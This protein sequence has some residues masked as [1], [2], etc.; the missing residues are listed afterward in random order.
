MAGLITSS[1]HLHSV[2]RSLTRSRENTN[3]NPSSRPAWHKKQYQITFL[4]TG[5]KT[6]KDM[7]QVVLDG[8]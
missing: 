6:G 4:E 2:S 8:G 7:R 1:Y 3:P 5:G